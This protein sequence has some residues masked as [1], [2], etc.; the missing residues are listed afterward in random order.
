MVLLFH[1]YCCEESSTG[2]ES[3]YLAYSIILEKSK[4][5][6]KDLEIIKYTVKSR[7]VKHLV[8]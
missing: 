8:A 6:L 1:S 3:I 5:E 2:E 4:Q 7:G